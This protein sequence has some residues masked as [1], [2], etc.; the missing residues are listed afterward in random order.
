[1]RWNH[2]VSRHGYHHH[3]LQPL[4]PLFWTAAM[5]WF[6]RLHVLSSAVADPGF[7]RR[8]SPT[9][10]VGAL[11]YYLARFFLKI[12]WK[13]KNIGP[14]GKYTS[15]QPPPPRSANDLCG[16]YSSSQT[17]LWMRH[18]L[19]S[20]AVYRAKI[21]SQLLQCIITQFLDENLIFFLADEKPK[22]VQ[23]IKLNLNTNWMCCACFSET[24][25]RRSCN[26]V[27]QRAKDFHPWFGMEQEY[28][29]LD[30]DK[31]PFGWPKNGF[32]GPQVE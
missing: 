10:K 20:L 16:M 14:R 8:G 9:P 7:P 2:T 29:L 24:N 4:I 28:I 1:M 23:E 11:T 19:N 18:L 30:Q 31:H 26:E 21:P 15:L 5:L 13:W 22:L 17:H 6:S 3:L 27:M 12:A 32:P 25:H